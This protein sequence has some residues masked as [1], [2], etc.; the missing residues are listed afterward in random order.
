MLDDLQEGDERIVCCGSCY[1]LKGRMTDWFG[2]G[3]L[4]INDMGV[5]WRDNLSVFRNHRL[6]PCASA[7]SVR[8]FTKV[9]YQVSMEECE[10]YEPEAS[11][12]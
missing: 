4:S 11:P 6:L 1:A 8:M 2:F 12:R 7:L 5:E 9:M 10:V 3:S